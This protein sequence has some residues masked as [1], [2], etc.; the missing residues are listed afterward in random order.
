MLKY[1]FYI[2]L[3]TSMLQMPRIYYKYLRE[4][5]LINTY[6]VFISLN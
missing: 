4:N 5:K 1:E 3:F 6:V 2:Y